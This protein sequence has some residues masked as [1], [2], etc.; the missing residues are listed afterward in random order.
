MTELKPC[1]F[2]GGVAKFC[3]VE[4][5]TTYD[6]RTRGNS[7]SIC[8]RKCGAATPKTDYSLELRMNDEGEI[9]IT[10]DERLSAIKAWNQRASE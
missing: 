3:I 6:Y 10:K 2:C 5:Y 8:C 9:E 4:V 7:F 1:P